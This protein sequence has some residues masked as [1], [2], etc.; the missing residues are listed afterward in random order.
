MN[1]AQTLAALL[2]GAIVI[3][4]HA[5]H[6]TTPPRVRHAAPRSIAHPPSHPPRTLRMRHVPHMPHDAMTHAARTVAAG[7]AAA[8]AA[9]ARAGPAHFSSMRYGDGCVGAH[10]PP[11][12]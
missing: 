2:T 6:Q 3:P 12:A 8:E 4:P 9:R 5:S 7:G 11:F 10:D 1:S